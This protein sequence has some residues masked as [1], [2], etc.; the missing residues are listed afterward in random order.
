MTAGDADLEAIPP[1][2]TLEILRQIAN[3]SLNFGYCSRDSISLKGKEQDDLIL[4]DLKERKVISIKDGFY[5][6]QVQLFQE[7][8]LNR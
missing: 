2:D 8:L 3:A 1:K 7:W 5:R 4:E 6:I